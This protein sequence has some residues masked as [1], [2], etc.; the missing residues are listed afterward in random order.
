MIITLETNVS[1][2][3]GHLIKTINHNKIFIKIFI[4]TWGMLIVKTLS[5]NFSR[6][7]NLRILKGALNQSG[8]VT[9]KTFFNLAGYPP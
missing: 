5:L 3:G 2:L 6:T 1:K 9:I 7:N 8:A 4:N